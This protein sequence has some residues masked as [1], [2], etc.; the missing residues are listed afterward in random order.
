MCRLIEKIFMSFINALIVMSLILFPVHSQKLNLGIAMAEEQVDPNAE[1]D[2]G[3]NKDGSP[4][5]YKVGCDF[6]KDLAK[7]DLKDHYPEGIKGIIEQ[8]VGAVFAL[9]GITLFWNPIPAALVE[10]PQHLGAKISFPM[11]QAGS[12]AYLLGEI[13]ANKEFEKASKIAVDKSFEAK[14]NE[15]YARGADKETREKSQ[16]KAI[17]NRKENDKQIEAYNALEKIYDHQVSGLDKKIKL[18]TAAEVAFIGAEVFE[19]TDLAENFVSAETNL[20][21]VYGENMTALAILDSLAGTIAASSVGSCTPLTSAIYGYTQQVRAYDAAMKAQAEAETA[22]KTAQTETQ[23]ASVTSGFEPTTIVT[24]GAG[25]SLVAVGTH[26]A[27]VAED[28]SLASSHDTENVT[29]KTTRATTIESVLGT[30]AAC[31]KALASATASSLGVGAAVLSAAQAALP[32]V[33]TAIAAVEG[34]RVMPI[35]CSGTQTIKGADLDTPI[36]TVS[37]LQ[38]KID[39]AFPHAD[40]AGF[41]FFKSPQNKYYVKKIMHNLFQRIALH[42]LDQQNFDSPEQRISQIAETSKYVKYMLEKSMH[43]LETYSFED[44]VQSLRSQLA[45]ISNEDDFKDVFFKKMSLLKGELI[46]SAHANSFKDLLKLGVKVGVLYF[47]MGKWLRNNAF[48]KPKNRI[49]TWGIMALVNAAVIKFDSDAQDDAKK[50]LSR[51]RE[52]RKKFIESHA[53][54]SYMKE[55]PSKGVGGD[56]KIV[57]PGDLLQKAGS[58]QV[59]A[60]AVPKGKSFAPAVCP[61]VVPKSRFNLTKG[62]GKIVSSGSLLGETLTGLGDVT[63]GAATGR[64]YSNPELME[65]SISNLAGKKNNLIKQRDALREKIDKRPVL[66]TKEG[67]KLKGSSLVKSS[68][69]FRKLYKGDPSVTGIDQGVVS[70]I[71]SAK[72]PELKKVEKKEDKKKTVTSLPKFK[73]P[74]APKTSGFDFDF[75]SSQEGGIKVVDSGEDSDIAKEKNLDEFIVNSGEV[76]ENSNVNIFKLISNRY[77]LSYPK[78]L[79]EKNQRKE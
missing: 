75:D 79:E 63:Y 54:D 5:I 52:E 4:K 77:L 35:L 64:Q 50:R 9:I 39:A 12:L 18:A 46:Q 55:D 37:Q 21:T 61:S 51:V 17:E 42:K 15:S 11:I 71:N 72:I 43:E 36:P 23:V 59:M 20:T 24:M 68:T 74:T 67:K 73:M 40:A 62:S 8:F 10:C 69:K 31:Q 53:M 57:K 45:K 3:K 16:K 56:G 1:C 7:S 44:E 22:A 27:E 19:L 6:N 25:G 65:A 29:A 70:S 49:V 38:N 76:N 14:K 26:N 78:L 58:G 41:D 2:D 13:A 60:C 47:V 28:A 30:V 66:K 34:V 32:S 33:P 48:P